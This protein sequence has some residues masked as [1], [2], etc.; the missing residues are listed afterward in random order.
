MVPRALR[1][2][3][4]SRTLS[5]GRVPGFLLRL[6]LWFPTLLLL[7]LPLGST[8][9]AS[10]IAAGNTAFAALNAGTE[11]LFLRHEKWR[12]IGVTEQA[13]VAVLVRDQVWR[14]TPGQKRHILAKAVCT[15]YQPFAA[16]A[17]LLALFVAGRMPWRERGWKLGAAAGLLHLA[18]LGAVAID[19]SHA[20]N[21]VRPAGTDEW[22][23]TVVALLH[24][25]VTDWP[26]G[27]FIVPLLLWVLVS[28]PWQD[29]GEAEGRIGRS[30]DFNL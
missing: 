12:E 16:S 29:A 1:P 23:R 7:W 15:F 3:A 8:Y 4:P 26:A 18:M 14:E 22:L 20:L 10:L 17:F 6:L 19:V 13:D 2:L 21:S 28:R 30:S 5:P 27:V 9:R 25:T 11:V 24:Y